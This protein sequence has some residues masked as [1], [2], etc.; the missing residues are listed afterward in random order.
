MTEEFFF[1]FQL[2]SQMSPEKLFSLQAFFE[3]RAKILEK[4]LN[5]DE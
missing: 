3:V 4:I 5:V 1:H 2:I